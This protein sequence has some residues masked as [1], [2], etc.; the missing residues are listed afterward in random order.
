M[1]DVDIK[2]KSSLSAVYK[3][4][5]KIKLCGIICGEN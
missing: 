3:C 5:F 1:Y 4:K 2:V